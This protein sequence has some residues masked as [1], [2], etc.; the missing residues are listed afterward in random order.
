MLRLAA[1]EPLERL[2]P[3]FFQELGKLLPFDWAAVSLPAL[4][5]ATPEILAWRRM[6]GGDG[7]A[8][9]E[10]LPAVA[11]AVAGASPGMGASLGTEAD[12]P[13][14]DPVIRIPLADAGG[15]ACVWLGRMGANLLTGAQRKRTASF[16]PALASALRRDLRDRQA[17]T[18]SRERSAELSTLFEVVRAAG[19]ALNSEELFQF[20][21]TALQPLV[22]LD[23]LAVATDL[24]GRPT[25]TFHLARLLTPPLQ[26]HLALLCRERFRQETGRMAGDEAVSLRHLPGFDPEEPPLDHPPRL[27]EA[28]PLKRRGE[29]VGVLV[30]A[31]GRGRPSETISRILAT[32]AGQASLTVDRLQS[33]AEAQA[34]QLR[35]VMDSLADGVVMT[36]LDGR[37]AISNTSGIE[38]LRLLQ[39]GGLEPFSGRLSGQKEVPDPSPFPGEVEVLD[40]LGGVRF[41]ELSKEALAGSCHVVAEI[42]LASPRKIFRLSVRPL[43][44][45]KDL[46]VGFVVV[47]SDITEARALQEQMLQTEKLSSLGEM[48][49]GVAHELNNPLAAVMGYAQLLQGT[50]IQ[51]DVR[52]KLEIIAVEA[53]RCQTIVR[54]LLSFARR[55]RPERRALSLNEIVR[56]VL[57]LMCYQLRVEGIEVLTELDSALPAIQ[58]DPH[59]LQ[60]A[61]LNLVSNAQHAIKGTPPPRRLTVR[62]AAHEAGVRVEVQDTGPGIPPEILPRI[63]DPF[64]TTKEVGQGTGLGLSIVFGIVESHQGRTAASNVPGGGALFAIDLP[65]GRGG[66]QVEKE[67]WRLESGPQPPVGGVPSKAILVVDDEEAICSLLQEVLAADGHRVDTAE[68]GGVARERLAARDYDLIITDLKMPGSGGRELYEEVVR[69]RPDLADRFVFATGDV[70]ST[71]AREFFRKTGRPFLEKPFDVRDLRRLVRTVLDGSGG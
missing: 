33:G 22:E 16:W 31:S 58:G 41:R 60:Q 19:R 13:G 54:N 12:L 11:R 66:T 45:A 4:P 7:F 36:G 53:G 51:D 15:P 14:A 25:L 62:T 50:K 1:D 24:E 30:F 32:A 55:H 38:H 18:T 37:V 68:D 34:R 64:F 56:S 26:Q 21:A 28:F 39:A 42:N 2:L 69:Q 6:E 43:A 44:G 8:P 48:I 29:C 61:L 71:E 46:A 67:S 70:V 35:A 52:R 17:A 23:A 63:F 20:L 5:G 57:G 10:D 47:T 40:D 9:S 65:Q 27:F 49:S 3:D 59:Q